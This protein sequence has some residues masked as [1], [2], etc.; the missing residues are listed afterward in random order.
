M[1]LRPFFFE[2]SNLD[3]FYEIIENLKCSSY[4]NSIDTG[5]VVMKKLTPKEVQ[6]DCGHTFTIDRRRLWCAKCANPVYYDASEKQHH[7]RST[8]YVY[9]VILAVITF[10][11]Y[12]FIE[13]IATPFLTW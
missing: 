9:A 12:I 2:F 3:F 10:L 4:G 8:I 7:K 11:T 6:C 1:I 13:L 5:I